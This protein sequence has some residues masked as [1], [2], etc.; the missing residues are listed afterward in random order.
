M[1]E[2]V[3]YTEETKGF[4]PMLVFLTNMSFGTRLLV[5]LR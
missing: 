1:I 5:T 2:I 3:D 4:A